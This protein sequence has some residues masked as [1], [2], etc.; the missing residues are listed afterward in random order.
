MFDILENASQISNEQVKKEYEV[1]FVE[2]ES[3]EKAFLLIRDVFLFTNKRLILVNKQGIIGKK[4]KVIF[5]P[6]TKIN[7]F[8]VET[9][10]DLD[11]EAELRIW[12]SGSSTY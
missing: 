9:T 8:S 1:L 12:I 2:D 10:G 5:I 6:Y 3:I 4:T 11:L 7:I